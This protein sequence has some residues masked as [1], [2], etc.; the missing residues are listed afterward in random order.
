MASVFPRERS[1]IRQTEATKTGHGALREGGVLRPSLTVEDASFDFEIQHGDNRKTAISA[2]SWTRNAA[3]VSG[4][5]C[6][7]D[8]TTSS[9]TSWGLERLSHCT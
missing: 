4:L 1:E 3:W 2:P 8:C 9:A 6:K 7:T 5:L